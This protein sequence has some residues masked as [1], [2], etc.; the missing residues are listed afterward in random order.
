M[1]GGNFRTDRE[2]LETGKELAEEG[3]VGEKKNVA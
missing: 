1:K 3:E 2:G